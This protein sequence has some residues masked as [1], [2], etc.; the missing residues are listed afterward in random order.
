MYIVI[1]IQ[2]S[3]FVLHTYIIIIIIITQ[4]LKPILD[5]DFEYQLKPLK[6]QIDTK[7]KI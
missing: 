5:T 1:L 6:P 7:T 3:I 2:K 4:Y